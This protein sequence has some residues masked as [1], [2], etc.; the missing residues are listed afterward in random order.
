MSEDLQLTYAD[1]PLRSFERQLAQ[2]EIRGL[3]LHVRKRS[4]THCLVE[5]PD[6][7]TLEIIARQLAFFHEVKSTND[8]VRTL[9]RDLDVS[10]SVA[11]SLSTST[12]SVQEALDGFVSARNG[13]RAVVH[14]YVTHGLHQYKGK[15]YPQIVKALLNHAGTIPK[16]VVLDPFVG[17]GTTTLEAALAGVQSVGIDLNPLAAFVAHTKFECLGIEPPRLEGLVTRIRRECSKEQTQAGSLPND[18][19]LERW[20]DPITRQRLMGLISGITQSAREQDEV[21]LCMTVLSNC[22]L[23]WSMQMPGQLRVRKRKSPPDTSGMLDEFLVRLVRAVAS[24][25]VFHA[26]QQRN[27]LCLVAPR[28]YNEDARNLSATGDPSMAPATVDTVVTSPPYATAL[29]YLDTDR[30]SLYLLDLMSPTER[31]RTDELMIGNREISNCRRR[32]LEEELAADTHLPRPVHLFLMRVLE[33]NRKN[34]IGFRRRNT[35]ALLYQYFTDMKQVFSECFSVLKP[36]GCMA[37]VIGNS[38][39]LL[40]GKEDVEIPTDRFLELIGL[41]LGF[42]RELRIP[43]TNQATY[44]AHSRN[45]IKRETIFLLRKPSS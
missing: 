31:L 30:L 22:V 18:E 2:L 20:F 1:Y 42:E 43:M 24:I 21:N 14:G 35:A 10:A 44:M 37:I 45:G 27:N 5:A 29:P 17:S 40:G 38:H 23:G 4:R 6:G 28:I 12:V 15:Y 8:A 9:Q 34:N 13:H 7:A 26:L 25:V 32:T 33:T 41:H 39:T 3:G 19:Y 11:R 36:G 16:G